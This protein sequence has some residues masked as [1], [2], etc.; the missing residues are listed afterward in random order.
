MGEEQGREAKVEGRERG[1]EIAD[2]TGAWGTL[3]TNR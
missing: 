1:Q 2:R 3:Y